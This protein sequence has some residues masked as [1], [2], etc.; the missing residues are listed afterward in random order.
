VSIFAHL[1]GRFLPDT[2]KVEHL[3]SI[4]LDSEHNRDNISPIASDPIRIEMGLR[5]RKEPPL[6]SL[7]PI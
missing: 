2:K 5:L 1:E 4:R 7:R 6:L 3:L